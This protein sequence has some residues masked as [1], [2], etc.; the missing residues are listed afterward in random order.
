[1]ANKNIKGITVEIDGSTMGLSKALSG[2]EKALNATQ[3][4]LREIDRLLKLDPGNTELLS[5]RQKVLA[6]QVN[7]TSEKLEKLRDVQDQI[8]R[9]YSSGEIDDGQYRAFRREIEKTEKALKNMSD[10]GEKSKKSLS[11]IGDTLATVGKGTL[12]V[13]GAVATGIMAIG[14][15][16]VA[17]TVASR[18]YREEMNKL[19]VSFRTNGH[20]A[21]TAKASYT[22]LIGIIGETEQAVEAAQQ[23]AL[24][25]DN[26]KD[27]AEW[28]GLAA[29]VVSKFGS[30]LQPETFYESANETLKLCT[31]TG[32][33]A[34]LL[35][36]CGYSVDE[37]NAGLAACSSAE[38][39]QQYML[40]VTNGLLGEASE[41]Y[42][43]VNADI[44]SQKQATDKWNAS[45]AK[46]GS[47]AEPVIANVTSLGADGL[48][49]LADGLAL[50]LSGDVEGCVE[51]ISNSVGGLVEGISSTA[52]TLMGMAVPMLEGLI[53]GIT[54]AIPMLAP[55]VVDIVYQIAGFLLDAVPMLLTAAITLVTELAK[56]IGSNMSTLLPELIQ[57]ILQLVADLLGN[58]DAIIDVAMQLVNGLV[59]GITSALPVLVGYLPT[60]VIALVD[61][62]VS[63]IPIILQGAGRLVLGLVDGILAAI[64]AL[65]EAAPQIITALI[66][67][68]LSALPTILD[69]A[70]ELVLGLANGIISAIP[71]LVGYI[72]ELVIAIINALIDAIPLLL[73][74]AVELILGLV[75]GIVEAIPIL[76]EMA[77]SIVMA[78][79][80]ALISAIPQL[81]MCAGNLIISLAQGLITAIPKLITAIPQIIAALINGLANSVSKFAEM[82]LNLVKG[83][84]EG[85]K[86]S[87]AW[88]KNKIKEWVGNVLDFI[89]G[90]FGIHSPA[91]TTEYF[92]KMLGQGLALGIEEDDTP[93]K[94]MEKKCKNIK[95]ILDDF[96]GGLSD[97]QDLHD[98]WLELWNLENPDASPIE[99]LGMALSMTDAKIKEQDDIVAANKTAWDKAIEEFG[100]DSAEAR[101]FE[102]LYAKSLID[103]KKLENERQGIVDE[104]LERE[105]YGGLTQ[106]EYE[107]A[108]KD[109]YTDEEIRALKYDRN[110]WLQ[111]NGSSLLE[112]GL[113]YEDAVQMANKATGYDKAEMQINNKTEVTIT[114]GTAYDKFRVRE[115][116]SQT[117]AVYV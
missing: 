18:D 73:D 79:I 110:A 70:I 62:L 109:D 98:A 91:T 30:A 59:E 15:G 102:E 7:A 3:G 14:T 67:G 108:H 58:V 107:E 113:T 101:R 32:A 78:L 63:A 97:R 106:K 34:Q 75:M 61:A 99:K 24:L 39:R 38:E 52:G 112:A 76:T 42:K 1:M 25:A 53:Q 89:K 41:E 115:T 114:N 28:S 19:D 47:T 117:E 90:L 9:Q 40:K 69:C 22:E 29:G 57:T 85:L 74:C 82:G 5:Q 77:P 84:W 46:I 2:A 88:I 105:Q 4:E 83:L 21:E 60:I 80:D 20:S 95:T 66:N 111:Q 16:V 49:A 17:A 93:E 94:A 45:M 11:G 103:R 50:A 104:A 72:P 56:A 71:V 6:Q 116:D 54:T 8:E 13:G 92:G 36:G 23:I 10:T 68:I 81:L 96:V 35:E 12:A 48:G 31:A 55:V 64:P 43:K 51:T 65:I 27:V 33:Y 86:N 26:E 37:F 100:A 44:I 87:V